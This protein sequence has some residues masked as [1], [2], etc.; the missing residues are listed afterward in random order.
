MMATKSSLIGDLRKL[1]V[2]EGDLLMVHAGLRSLGPVVGGA[3][4]VVQALLD[5]VG[6][7]GT[8]VAYVDFEPFY[9]DGDPEIPEFDRLTARAAVDHGVLH[10][11]I[12][13]WPGAIRSDHPDAGVVAIGAGAGWITE[14]HSL[15][16]GY[17]AGSPFAKI[18]EGEGRVLMLGAP[19]DAITI[20]HY[21][22]SLAE[23]PDK[24][25]KRYQRKMRGL[26]WV[27]IEEYDTEEPVHEALPPGYF[28]RIAEDY[29]AQGEGR[30]GLVGQAP[31][32]LFEAAGLVRFGVRWI[33]RY[34]KGAA[35]HE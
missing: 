18:V 21:A 16:Y 8:L 33:E 14:G 10:E 4:I 3:A 12:R 1:G 30:C 27:D 20:L 6:S 11:V 34:V 15:Q 32:Y 22:E 9:E 35:S 24:R 5:A 28:E 17:G 2:R 26:G 31:S 25:I 13:T 23:I 19:L 7:D 29:R